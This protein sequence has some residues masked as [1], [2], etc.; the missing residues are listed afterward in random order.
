M[1]FFSHKLTAVTD[2]L[3]VIALMLLRAAWSIEAL[4]WDPFRFRNHEEAY[5]ATVGWLVWHGGLWSDLLRM[6]YRTFCGGCTAVSLLAAPTLGILGDRFFVFKGL[7]I[8]WG[9]ACVWAGYLAGTRLWGR[10]AGLALALLL[11]L[12]SRGLSE[13]SLMMWG[14]HQ[15]TA[16]LLLIALALLPRGGLALGVV[17]GGSLWFCRTSGYFVAVLLLAA[18]LAE[19]G[20][21][22]GRGRLLAGLALGLSPLLLPAGAGATGQVSMSPADHLLPEGLAGGARRLLLLLDPAELA[23]RLLLSRDRAAAA[24]LVLVN[25][26]VAAALLVRQ[27]RWL[28]LALAASFVA[29]FVISGFH[30]PLPG[31]LLPVVNVRYHAPWML[32]LLLLPASAVVSRRSALLLVVPLAVALTGPLYRQRQGPDYIPWSAPASNRWQLLSAGA[33]RL[34]PAH[35]TGASDPDADQ[36]VALLRGFRGGSVEDSPAAQAGA[37]L[38]GGAGSVAAASVVRALRGEEPGHDF[39]EG[40]RLTARCQRPDPAAFCACVQAARPG[41]EVLRGVGAATA[42]PWRDPAE[43]AAISACLG[44]AFREGLADPLAGVATW[45]GQN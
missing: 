5:N 27:R 23:P 31:R 15:E 26:A 45:G 25:A 16:L 29:A 6:Q 38:S 13:V 40:F 19:R 34:S 9:M 24:G 44:P 3:P 39:G 30:V 2:R 20:G 1:S 18:L 21:L 10:P 12:P 28:P 37:A 41:A 35:L 17:L 22:A 8:G 33:V 4:L 36:Y 7:A 43:I 42:D 14:N 11:A 32:L